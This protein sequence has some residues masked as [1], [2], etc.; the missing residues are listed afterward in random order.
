MGVASEREVIMIQSQ[1][2]D[3]LLAVMDNFKTPGKQLHIT[4]ANS[5]QDGL[6]MILS[7]ENLHQEKKLRAALE[8]LRS[9]ILWNDRVGAVSIVGT[10]INVSNQKM[11]C[12]TRALEKAGIA[13]YGAATSSFRITWIVARE[14]VSAALGLL[15]A[16]FIER[17]A[18]LVP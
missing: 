14:K 6:T 2:I 8:Q 13:Y 12:G 1:E 15:H 7:K 3:R 17:D 9:G 18:P 11:L 10:G 5:R 4:N 16:L